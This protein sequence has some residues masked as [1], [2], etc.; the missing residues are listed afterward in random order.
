V[1]IVSLCPSIT[2]SLVALG[3][4]ESLAGIT[5]YCIHPREAL[6]GIRRVG[7]TKNPDLAAIRALGP[8]LVFC[9]SEEN[10]KEDI[11]ALK[12]EF[13]VDVSHPRTVGEIPA[14][15][16]HF[17]SLTGKEENAEGFSLKV[18]KAL[19]RFED[20]ARQRAGG[21]SA[22]GKVSRAGG[23]G[24]SPAFRF[25]YLIW[26]DPWMTVGPRTYVADLLRRV[27]GSLSLEEKDAEGPD[28][29]VA[30]EDEIVASR[31][32]VLILPDEPYRFRERDAAF[33][34][35]RMPAS[36]RVILVSGDD[37]CWHGVRTIRGLEA[38]AQLA[39]ELAAVTR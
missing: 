14:L 8:D 30:A 3:L 28:Y 5:R 21:V 17:G 34:R 25:V 16:R 22:A 29:P 19:E 18:E 9:N 10:R 1:R 33:W 12:R 38:A 15:L 24:S 13:G 37:F 6:A 31:P 23:G 27:R 26:K 35:Q 2:E 36:T 7:G 11:E 4:A 20:E 39:R 32:D